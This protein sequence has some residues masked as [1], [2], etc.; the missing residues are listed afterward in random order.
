MIASV[1]DDINII[2]NLGVNPDIK[3]LDFSKAGPV[4]EAAA[5]IPDFSLTVNGDTVTLAGTAAT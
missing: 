5:T 4:F 3:A 1:G 2:D